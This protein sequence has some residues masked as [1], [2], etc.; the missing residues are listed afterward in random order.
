LEIQAIRVNY[1][2]EI[3]LSSGESYLLSHHHPEVEGAE[4]AVFTDTS[5]RYVDCTEG[6]CHLLGYDRPELL[7]RTIDNVS[8]H[9]DEVSKLFAEYLRRGRM[10]GEYVL[11]H[12]SG[13]PVS[14][15][16][17][18]F[19]FSDGCTA[20]V[21]D[22]IKSWRDLYL[23]ALVEI[24]PVALKRK[25]DL[26]LLAVERR[27]QEIKSSPSVAGAEQQSL[28]DAA[29]ALKSLMRNS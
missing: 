4:F 28:R 2:S 9:E 17:R 16:Y 23:A 29:S 12:K 26:A 22:P 1:S 19:V 18:A 14:I 10:D 15:R 3:H 11:R 24:D 27:A 8:F 6:V 21:W 25:V 7:A 20:A 5:R 13:A